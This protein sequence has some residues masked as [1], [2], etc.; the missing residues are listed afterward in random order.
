MEGKVHGYASNGVEFE[1]YINLETGEITNFYPIIKWQ[2]R[3]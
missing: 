1:G 2:V 3:S